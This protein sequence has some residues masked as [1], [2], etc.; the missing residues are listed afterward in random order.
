MDITACRHLK[1]DA[2]LAIRGLTAPQASQRLKAFVEEHNITP[3]ERD[4]LWRAVS[5]RPSEGI[6][7]SKDARAGHG[8]GMPVLL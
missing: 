7:Y 2:Q 3:G 6:T 5:L 1:R 8:C 4:A